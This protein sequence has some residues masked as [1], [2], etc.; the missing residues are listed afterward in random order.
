MMYIFLEGPNQGLFNAVSHVA[1]QYVVIILQLP[2]CTLKFI[3]FEYHAI[4][5][6]IPP[7]KTIFGFLKGGYFKVFDDPTLKGGILRHFSKVEF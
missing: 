4:T 6:R 7:F 2:S 1:V 3:T 5:L